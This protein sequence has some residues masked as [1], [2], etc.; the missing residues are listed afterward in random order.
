MELIPEFLAMGKKVEKQ[1]SIT[2]DTVDVTRLGLIFVIMF[3]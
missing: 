3:T 2:Q 1:R